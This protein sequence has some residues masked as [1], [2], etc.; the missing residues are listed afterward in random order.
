MNA[1]T[2]FKSTVEDI[3]AAG[4]Y[5]GPTLINKMLGRGRHNNHL[6]GRDTHWRREVM[7]KHNIPLMRPGADLPLTDYDVEWNAY[8]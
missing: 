3:I 6:N 4:A 7:K 2:R 5:P 8:L 1:E